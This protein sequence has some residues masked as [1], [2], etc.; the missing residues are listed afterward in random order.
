MRRDADVISIAEALR[1]LKEH[2]ADN[3]GCGNP[4]K[5]VAAAEERLGIRFPDSYRRFLLEVGYAEVF[6]DEIFSIYDQPDDVPCLGVVQQNVKSPLL[7][8]GYLRFLSTDIDGTFL[9]KVSDGTV[10]LND[11]STPVAESFEHLIEKLL[12]S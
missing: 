6:G 3:L 10:F 2:S 7:E 11:D 5:I 8:R 12:T 4:E 9:I 1:L